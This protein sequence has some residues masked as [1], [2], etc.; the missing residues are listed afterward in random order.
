MKRTKKSRI[1]RSETRIFEVLFSQT[2]YRSKKANKKIIKS[3]FSKSFEKSIKPGFFKFNIFEI[4]NRWRHLSKHGV[5]IICLHSF[6]FLLTVLKNKISKEIDKK[7]TALSSFARKKTNFLPKTR[8]QT[9]P[10]EAHR[11]RSLLP[12]LTRLVS[13]EN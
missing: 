10:E 6:F 5:H 9:A 11:C 4:E 12:D 7:K 13:S 1:S 3:P 8:A 2:F